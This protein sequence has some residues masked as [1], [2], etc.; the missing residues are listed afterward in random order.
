VEIQ[1]V[2]RRKEAIG[3]SGSAQRASALEAFRRKSDLTM[4]RYVAAWLHAT[5][6]PRRVRI[7]TDEEE[8]G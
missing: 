5:A 8:E 1:P 2:F 4:R 7:G 3:L 6:Q